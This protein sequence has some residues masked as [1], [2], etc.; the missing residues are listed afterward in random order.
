MINLNY[1]K[2]TYLLLGLIIINIVIYIRF[3]RERIPRD[4]Y[5]GYP[6]N[7]SLCIVITTGFFV[8]LYIIY[9]NAKLLYKYDE[10]ESLLKKLTYKVLDIIEKALFEDFTFVSR[11]IGPKSYDLLSSFNRYFYKSCSKHHEGLLFIISSFIRFIISITFLIDVFVFF[12]FNYFYK[13]LLLLIIPISI[14]IVIFL[15]KNFASNLNF[16][17][18]FLTITENDDVTTRF[19][20]S[21]GNEDID[22]EYHIEQYILCNKING[23]LEIY[24]NFVTFYNPRVSIVIYLLYLIGWLFIIFINVHS[25]I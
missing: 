22:L 12:K 14:S 13:S 21:P 4:L 20:P 18:S 25:F 24:N 9:I 10:K 11:I 8:S 5:V 15:L 7:I 17:S 3:L 6:V 1:K 19:K 23:Y 16:M 2:Y